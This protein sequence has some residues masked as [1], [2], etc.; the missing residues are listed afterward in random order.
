MR[1]ALLGDK[2][3]QAAVHHFLRSFTVVPLTAGAGESGQKTHARNEATRP[4]A[5]WPNC[6]AG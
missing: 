4:A 6:G 1:K 3:P 5:F 2:H